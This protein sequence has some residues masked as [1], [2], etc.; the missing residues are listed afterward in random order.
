MY[1]MCVD[2]HLEELI[3]ASYRVLYVGY[4]PAGRV[5][6]VLRQSELFRAEIGTK[7]ISG[8]LVAEVVSKR[9]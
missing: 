4:V 7:P 3:Y 1:P 2:L 9:R 8:A 6:A 5:L